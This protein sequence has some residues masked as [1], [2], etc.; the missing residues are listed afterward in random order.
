MAGSGGEDVRHIFLLS[1]GSGFTAERLL[2]AALVQFPGARTRLH[3]FAEVRSASH[4]AEVVERAREA[5][6]V[7]LYTF[8]AP[9]LTEAMER[10]KC[11]GGIVAFDLLGPLIRELE[12]CLSMRAQA[13]PGL[14]HQVD[15][16]YFKRLDAIGFAV[17]HDDGQ[18]LHSL[19]EADLVLAGPSRT[20]KTPTSVY[21]AYNQGLRAG[22]VPLF[23]ESEP[24]AEL[25][26]LPRHKVVGL[27]MGWLRLVEVRRTRGIP[28]NP[29]YTDPD[30]VRQELRAADRLYREQGWPSVDVTGRS[31]EEV[32]SEACRVAGLVP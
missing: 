4:L 21:L 11:R 3:R 1:D 22:N 31:I 9:D 27:T 24:P 8:V 19:A 2:A 30:R 28:L 14:L 23:L 6:G 18:G 13:Q 25:L 26:S 10:E 17:K 16:H 7:V 15:A 12:H 5:R 20:G 32:A 29:N